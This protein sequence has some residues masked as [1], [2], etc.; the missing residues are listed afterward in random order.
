MPEINQRDILGTGDLYT[1]VPSILMVCYRILFLDLMMLMMLNCV[2][3]RY[4]ANKLND[5]KTRQDR[6][7]LSCDG[8][9]E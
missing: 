8:C 1:Q 7:M 3:S 2:N 5:Q 9:F 6:Y 4:C